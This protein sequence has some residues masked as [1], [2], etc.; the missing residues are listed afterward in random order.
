[1]RPRPSLRKT[2]RT[3]QHSLAA[4]AIPQTLLRERG[5]GSA[6]SRCQ[7]P[8]AR[9]EAPGSDSTTR[10]HARQCHCGH[11]TE[12]VALLAAR[13]PKLRQAVR[14]AKKAGHAYAVIDAR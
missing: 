4:R 14:E 10:A 7:V 11:A 5:S 3:D 8:A 2:R 1:M 9:S 12:T 13:S 6:S